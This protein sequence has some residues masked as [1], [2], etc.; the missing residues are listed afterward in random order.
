MPSSRAA[1]RPVPPHPRAWLPTGAKLTTPAATDSAL[2]YARDARWGPNGL[3]AVAGD[4]STASPG[5]AS[6]YARIVR[7]D[8]SLLT[9][10]GALPGLPA[11][12]WDSSGGVSYGAAWSP[13]GD[14]L[15]IG[16]FQS[17]FIH[18]YARTGAATFTKLSDPAT[19][20]ADQGQQPAYSPCGRLLAVAHPTTPF[21]TIYKRAGDT[22][23]K[24]TNP[25]TLPTGTGI[26]CA[27]SS[28]GQFLA[29]A[30]D[31]SPYVT[32]YALAAL[33]GTPT[34]TKISNPASLPAGF[35]LGVA[36][37]P[38]SRYMAVGHVTSPFVTV[39]RIDGQ[40]FTKLANPSSLPPSNVRELSWGGRHGRTLF[41]SNDA[42]PYHIV[43]EVE[44]DT[45]RKLTDLSGTNPA[46]LSY[47]ADQHPA[48][49]HLVIAGQGGAA[50]HVYANG[51]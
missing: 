5:S 44:G 21:V 24:Q 30:H 2:L 33:S 25:G 8:G 1:A 50:I 49:G 28:D 45:I 37:S 34:F 39:Y 42:S 22:Y 48:S 11:G 14:H 6:D 13:Q 10:L 51:G 16:L 15:A 40:T 12:N 35:S 9:D 17:P 7:L 27:F 43:Y 32:I 47:S 41:C 23:T 4:T 36:F 20:P 3:L 31:T 18:I 46:A 38:D 29:V 19:L 26:S